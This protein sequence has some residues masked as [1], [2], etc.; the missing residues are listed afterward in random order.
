VKDTIGSLC[1]PMM[2]E[3]S[4][5]SSAARASATQWSAEREAV[6]EAEGRGIARGGQVSGSIVCRRCEGDTFFSMATQTHDY[7]FQEG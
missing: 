2:E 3:K 4:R 6:A 7:S 1:V 5:A